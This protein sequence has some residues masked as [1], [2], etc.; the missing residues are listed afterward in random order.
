MKHLKIRNNTFILLIVVLLVVTPFLSAQAD[1]YGGGGGGSGSAG[2]T[3]L[4]GDDTTAQSTSGN[5][6]S[7]SYGKTNIITPSI[8]TS[9]ND[10]SPTGWLTS[11]LPTANDIRIT[12][13][14]YVDI[15]G[16]AAPTYNTG[17]SGTAEGS[18]VV[19]ECASGATNFPV[20]LVANSGSSMAANQFGF[21]SNIYLAPG[22][23]V[24]II[25]DNTASLWREYGGHK[26][27]GTF[28]YGSGSDGNVT[29]SSGTTTLVRDMYYRNLTITGGQ[30]ATNQYRVYV[31]EMLDIS[32]APAGAITANGG[33]GGNGT[34]AGGAGG[35]GARSFSGYVA[36]PI[37]VA[38]LIGG[39]G[40]AGGGNAG[41]SGSA[42][43]TTVLINNTAAAGGVGGTGS[44]GTAGA[45]GSGGTV[46]TNGSPWPFTAF[47]PYAYL[48]I[49]TADSIAVQAGAGG[50]GSGDSTNAGGG[51][52][53][54]GT[55]GGYLFLSARFINRGS[56]ST[57][58]IFQA[59]GGAGG[60]GGSPAAG[61]PG[62][63]GGGGGG[64]GGQMFLYA[65]YLIGS[66]IT[67]ALD[68]TG[69]SG[70]TGGTSPSTGTGG[71]GGYGG[72][73]GQ[74]LF[75]NLTS[76]QSTL[77]SSANRVIGTSNTGVTGGAGG[78]ATTTQQNL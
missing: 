27:I 21:A 54:S 65:G 74:I 2:I 78:V 55:S 68:V 60:N 62:G 73:S 64:C 13:T 41:T 20:R 10:W 76:G 35:A 16:L 5:V 8:S 15:T 61:T 49:V 18:V 69:G 29:I 57:A 52:G 66:T 6:A 45:A 63:G 67:G 7:F 47:T 36:L 37:M 58:G 43:V 59:K 31:Q 24:T 71:T 34:A 3:G 14:A 40:G 46:T 4:T 11:S 25:Y 51:G 28:Y 77:T 1:M 53:G 30:L 19:L 23:A 72:C 44:G 38:G 9:Q 39:A 12:A 32:S 48:S 56:S 17:T 26:D 70:G 22:E 50:G 33:A 75:L 42:G